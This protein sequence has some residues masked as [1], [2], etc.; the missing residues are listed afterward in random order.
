VYDRQTV[1]TR[2]ARLGEAARLSEQVAQGDREARDAT[3][4]EAHAVG[5][6]SVREIARA[7]G[8]SVARTQ[9]VI[10]RQTALAQARL[11]AALGLDH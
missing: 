8:I 11:V 2:L 1:L 9:E 6:L 3:I 4:Y 7:T 10:I 5:A